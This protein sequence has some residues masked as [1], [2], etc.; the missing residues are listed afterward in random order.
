[1]PCYHASLKGSPMPRF[2]LP[3]L[4]TAALPL[5]AC[6]SAHTTTAAG[7]AGHVAVP[8]DEPPPCN[9]EPV[10]RLIGQKASAEIIAQALKASGAATHRVLA[11]NTPA[12]L[13]LSHHRLNVLTDDANVITAL[14]CG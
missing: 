12:T 6:Q 13:D 8:Q 4:L 3:L 5:A 2:Y 9:A 7:V 14:H 1:M 11:P 10:Q